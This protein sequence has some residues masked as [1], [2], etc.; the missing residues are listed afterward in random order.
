MRALF[1][2]RFRDLARGVLDLFGDH[3]ADR[4]D[5]VRQVDVHVADRGAH[6]FG[7]ADQGF[8]LGD[9]AVDQAA[10]ARFVVGIG[11]F[12]RGDFVVHEAFEF[13]SARQRTL[14]AVAD[15]G[16]LAAH[17]LADADDAVAR[18]RLRLG[19]PQ[20]DFR[21]GLADQTQFLRARQHRGE[22]EEQCNRRKEAADQADD[23]RQRT[24]LAHQFADFGGIGAEHHAGEEHGPAGGEQPGDNERGLGRAALQRAQDVAD[25]FAVVVGGAAWR[26]LLK[27][28]M[29]RVAV[30][31]AVI[32][33][34]DLRAPVAAGRADA[35]FLALLD[36]PMWSA[37]A[38][39]TGS[40]RVDAV[41]ST[42]PAGRRAY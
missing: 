42:P 24:A 6:L 4:A 22:E 5:F 18:H 37:G 38:A 41:G 28:G 35:R 31:P 21:H 36:G 7:M 20:R 34:I 29:G 10:H 16:D 30:G 15:G 19:Q 17:G 1:L 3:V 25:A 12:Q 2:E 8:A 11:A 32:A 40:R 33:I 13:G 27:C 9:D 26:W 14:D 39:R 23:D